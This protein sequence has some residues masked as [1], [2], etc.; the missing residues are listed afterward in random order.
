VRHF[1][2][3]GVVAY[4]V[5]APLTK[6]RTPHKSEDTGARKELLLKHLKAALDARQNLE[7]RYVVIPKRSFYP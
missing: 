4:A 2:R 1:L 7:V 6:L 3:P 5:Y